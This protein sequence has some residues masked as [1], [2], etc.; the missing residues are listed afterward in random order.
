MLIIFNGLPTAVISYFLQ[1]Q[2]PLQW[3]SAP[4]EHLLLWQGQW[5]AIAGNAMLPKAKMAKAIKPV[6][7][8][9]FIV[10]SCPYS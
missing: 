1:L 3:H 6:V 5:S 9:G 10:L 4:Q 7:Q 8:W 2:E